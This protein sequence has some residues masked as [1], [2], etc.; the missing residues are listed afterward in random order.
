MAENRRG[1]GRGLYYSSRAQ[2]AVLAG[3]FAVTSVIVFFLGI[4]IGQGIEENK[5]LKE[6][7]V[8]LVKIPVQPLARGLK[9]GAADKEEMTFYDTLAKAPTGA[10]APPGKPAKKIKPPA[11]APK[12]AIKE[13][14]PAAKERA[15]V[16]RRRVQEKAGPEKAA[17]LPDVKK[18]S[19]ALK[20]AKAKGVKARTET[21][22]GAWTVQV[23]AYPDQ[24]RAKVLAKRLKEKGYDAYVVSTKIKG[25]T[26]YR[27]RV[28]RLATQEQAKELQK[29]LKRKENI[30]QSF[31]TSQ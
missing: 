21:R 5:I 1:K 4:L 13:T 15:T 30:T 17:S 10:K 18:K 22:K 29:T 23:N 2:L 31:T 16:S 20:K 12:P 8:P 7:E 25:R 3:G 11:K 28:G 27:V 9:P 14:K 6:K 19:P 26:W 24:R